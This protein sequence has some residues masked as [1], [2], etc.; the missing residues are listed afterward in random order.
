MDET[1]EADRSSYGKFAGNTEDGLGT[2]EWKG[3]LPA[4]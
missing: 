3:D 2:G 1:E 4:F